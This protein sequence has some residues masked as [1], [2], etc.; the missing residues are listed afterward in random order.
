LANVELAQSYLEQAKYEERSG[1]LL[2][3]AQSYERAARGKPSAQILERAAYCLLEGKGDLRKA[4]EL[5]RRAIGLAPNQS[6]PRVTLARIYMAASM[7]ESAIKELERASELLPGDDSIKDWI[8]RVR[9]GE[10]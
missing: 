2:E 1:R 7:R 9:R 3:A 4:G 8:K 5:A 10:V 6:V